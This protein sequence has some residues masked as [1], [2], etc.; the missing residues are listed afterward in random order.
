MSRSNASKR[1]RARRWGGFVNV[2]RGVVY[3]GE[4]LTFRELMASIAASARVEP[5]VPPPWMTW[6]SEP[7]VT[8]P[9][10][11]PVRR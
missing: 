5:L 10:W 8:L 11:I 2:D 3:C 6:I 4:R 7:V 9:P 1:L